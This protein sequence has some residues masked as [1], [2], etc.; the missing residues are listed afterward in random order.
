M[1]KNKQDRGPDK[2]FW[3]VTFS[4][5]L[6]LML[7]F[8]V[9]LLSMSVMN[10]DPLK[11]I[12]SSFQEGLGILG[13]GG[14]FGIWIAPREMVVPPRVPAAYRERME[15]L[16][17]NLRSRFKKTGPEVELG[18]DPQTGNLTLN[19]SAGGM[20]ASASTRLSEEARYALNQIADVLR[21]IPGRVE[22]SGHTDNVPMQG[23]GRKR[24]NWSLSLARAVNVAGYL[25]EDRRL[26]AQRLAVA[27]YGPSRPVADNG[28]PEGRAANRRITIEVI[29]EPLSGQ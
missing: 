26:D 16:H 10:Q 9:L 1:A 7:T 25:V 5:L 22:V 29:D 18:T 23:S 28:T 12:S 24:D 19:L 3:M 6:S 20:F 27:G 15:T 21:H 14:P 11:K 17:D 8:F 13:N 2:S 4:D